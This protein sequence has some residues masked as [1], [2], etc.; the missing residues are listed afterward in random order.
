MPAQA[1]LVALAPE[2]APVSLSLNS[3]GIY[4]GSATGA[5]VGALVIAH[6]SVGRLG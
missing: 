3:S 5:A 6:A 2:L 1:R 4:L